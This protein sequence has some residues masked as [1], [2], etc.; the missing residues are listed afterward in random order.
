MADKEKQGQLGSCVYKP[1]RRSKSSVTS[2][3]QWSLMLKQQCFAFHTWRMI[4]DLETFCNEWVRLSSTPT[5][6]H[7]EF[8]TLTINCQSCI[9]DVHALCNIGWLEKHHFYRCFEAPPKSANFL[10]LSVPS[11]RSWAIDPIYCFIEVKSS[12]RTSHQHLVRTE[13]A[14]SLR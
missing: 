10:L 5:P 6:V 8:N 11:I 9:F 7:R 1:P 3:L 13:Q 14:R 12:L 4:E 2:N